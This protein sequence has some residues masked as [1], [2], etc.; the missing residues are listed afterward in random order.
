MQRIRQYTWVITLVALAM[1]LMARVL[2]KHT[3]DRRQIT[4]EPARKLQADRAGALPV[5]QPRVEKGLPI[6]EPL[7]PS[8]WVIEDADAGG[9]L[10]GTLRA[11]SDGAVL[12]RRQLRFTAGTQQYT[13]TT[14]RDGRFS[15]QPPEPGVYLVTPVGSAAQSPA[16]TTLF[17]SSP[18]VQLV[19]VVLYVSTGD[20]EPT[21]TTERDAGTD[22]AGDRVPGRVVSGPDRSP[23]A[24]FELVVR[25][26]V[27]GLEANV[28]MRTT[29]LDAQGRFDLDGLPAGEYAIQVFAAGLAPAQGMV[30]V[31]RP[32]AA[33]EL[34][35]DLAPGGEVAGIV[36]RASDGQPLPGAR[37]VLQS[38]YALGMLPPPVELRTTSDAD[39]R[40][41]IPG[42]G[43]A[44]AQL[45]VSA[46]GHIPQVRPQLRLT[47]GQRTDVELSLRHLGDD[48]DGDNSDRASERRP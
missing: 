1:L 4:D 32:L 10:H 24:A 46:D 31:P 35:I 45:E 29:V 11:A 25:R 3:G 9:A 28:V 13:V 23:V 5:E 8:P 20:D 16:H 38:N 7:R 2:T 21:P 17:R 27:A 44:R 40:F 41:R 19:Q 14:D 34:A 36:K 22:D 26:I 33:S 30:T 12:P 42:I 18:G 15:W 39:G 6:A 48:S 37:I 47:A 43:A